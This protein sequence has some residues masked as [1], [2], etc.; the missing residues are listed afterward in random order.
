MVGTP[1]F[2]GDFPGKI[3]VKSHLNPHWEGFDV[4]PRNLYQVGN[5]FHADGS[6]SPFSN[7]TGLPED[8]KSG[9]IGN[10]QTLK[11]YSHLSTQEYVKRRV[12]Y[13]SFLHEDGPWE[14]F[15]DSR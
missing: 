10:F 7:E 2:P 5:F 6:D 1:H 9:K 13:F 12:A 14:V 15:V 3:P 11:R 8:L 4:G